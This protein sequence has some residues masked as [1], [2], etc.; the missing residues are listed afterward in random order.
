MSGKETAIIIPSEPASNHNSSVDLPLSALIDLPES[1]EIEANSSAVAL[2]DGTR[3]VG[4]LDWVQAI[5]LE[6]FNKRK[7]GIEEKILVNT[8]LHSSKDLLQP[9]LNHRDGLFF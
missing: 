9:G 7:A 8:F 5:E 6:E 2:E 4:T 3:E 1:D